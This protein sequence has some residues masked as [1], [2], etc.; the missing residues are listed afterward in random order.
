MAKGSPSLIA[1]LG[2]LA[3]AG[4]QNRDKL[5]EVLNTRGSDPARPGDQ[6]SPL[7]GF[8]QMLG[9]GGVMGGL[10]ELFERFSNPVQKAKVDS[11]VQ[12]GPNVPLAPDELE[13]ALDEET[14]AELGAKTGLSREELLSRLSTSLPEVVDQVT[15]EGQFPPISAPEPRSI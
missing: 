12:R 3:V 15:P 13:A 9:G 14:L 10:S 1:L 6:A 8:R 11:W 7:D 5:S 2:L 4:Y